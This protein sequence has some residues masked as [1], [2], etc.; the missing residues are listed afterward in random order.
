MKVYNTIEEIKADIV[1]RKLKINSSVEFNISFQ[2]DASIEVAGD[3]K[4]RNIKA[5]DINAWDIRAWNIEAG[6][7]RAWNIDAGNI[8]AGDIK[9]GD[10]KA[11][12]IRAGDIKALDIE[13]GDISFWA[14]CFAR[15][16]FICK[17]VKGRRE[18]NKFFCL[19]SEIVYAKEKRKVTHAEIIEKFG[20]DVQI[21]DEQ[22]NTSSHETN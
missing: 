17:S 20:E 16:S 10:I 18:N 3:I 9:A 11:G 15:M 12:S 19:D 13:A 5:W 21:V 7:I 6:D 14:V 2:V 8:K 4:A 22:P 1:D